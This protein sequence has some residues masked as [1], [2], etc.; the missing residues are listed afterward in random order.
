[1]CGVPNKVIIRT[2]EFEDCLV[3]IFYFVYTAKLLLSAVMCEIFWHT[4]ELKG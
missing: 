1:M 3:T 2:I 4:L